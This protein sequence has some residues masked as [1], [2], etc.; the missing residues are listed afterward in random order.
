MKIL[1]AV[2]ATGNGHISRAQQ[3]IPHLQQYGEVDI[4]L[5]G[6][7]ASLPTGFPIKYKSKGLSLFYTTCGG[8]DYKRMWYDNSI[9]RA[10]K[11]AKD[12][13]V[14][15]YDIVINDFEYIT[16]RACKIKNIPSIQFGHQASFKSKQTP[17]PNKRNIVGEMLLKNYAKATDYLGLHFRQYDDFILP[18][19]IKK[20]IIE[21]DVRNDWHISIYL[22]AYKIQCL[23][24]VL[25]EMKDVQFHWFLK[26]IKYT[27]TDGNIIY[28]PV[29][30]EWFNESLITCNGLI[31]G[32]GFETPA[33]ALFLQKKLMCIPIQSQYEQQ[34]NVAALKQIGVKALDK[35]KTDEFKKEIYEWLDTPA[36]CYKQNANDISST[37]SFLINKMSNYKRKIA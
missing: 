36:L 30:N 13:P 10:H 21:A 16:S 29:N 20:E 31:T 12:L 5:S 3:L 22:P 26:E 25:K 33:E 15:N 7:N 24:S 35:I 14:E 11:E 27:K 23:E 1:Y 8:L 34:C 9:I 6:A 18:P 2:Q 37:I 19:V 4:F 32:G 28:F 17:R